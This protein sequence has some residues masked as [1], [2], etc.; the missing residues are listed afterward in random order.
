MKQTIETLA[1]SFQGVEKRSI[2]KEWVKYGERFL[3]QNCKDSKYPHQD[4]VLTNFTVS[5]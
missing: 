2:G 3:T 1:H 4:L 5:P